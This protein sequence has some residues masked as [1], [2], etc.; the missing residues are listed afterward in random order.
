MI[1]R[2]PLFNR[3]EVGGLQD[4]LLLNHGQYIVQT[5]PGPQILYLIGRT[6]WV[7]VIK[8]H[9][10]PA[11]TNE[12]IEVY[13]SLTHGIIDEE[14]KDKCKILYDQDELIY[15]V[16][17]VK[18]QQFH[19]TNCHDCGYFAL[20]VIAEWW[21]EYRTNTKA[22]C[23][24]FDQLKM[25]EH[26]VFCINNDVLNV[27]PR[28]SEEAARAR[29]REAKRKANN[30]LCD[31]SRREI[32][33]KVE[34][35]KV[36]K[37]TDTVALERQGVCDVDVDEEEEEELPLTFNN[38]TIDV[39]AAC[40]IN[41]VPIKEVCKGL[42][43]EYM[44]KNMVK[45]GHCNASMWPEER[46]NKNY[47]CC[48]GGVVKLPPLPSPP[49]ELMELFQN[50]NNIGRFFRKHVRSFNNRFSFVSLKCNQTTFT[51]KG[52]KVFNIQG[53]LYHR[54]GSLC[55]QD[56]KTPSFAQL[57]L[58]SDEKE[59]LGLRHGTNASL[60][61]RQ[62]DG[63]LQK[64]IHQHNPLRKVYLTA[65][66]RLKEQKE[67]PKFVVR[68]PADRGPPTGA[69]DRTYN[70]PVGDQIAAL[71]SDESLAEPRDIMLKTVKG[72]LVHIHETHNLCDPLSYPL[73]FP[74]GSPG[75]HINLLLSC[76]NE[77]GKIRKRQRL[78]PSMYYTYRFM[79]RESEMC[80]SLLHRGCILFQQFAVDA[81]TKV[82]IY[83]L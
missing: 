58:C 20:A 26:V 82:K 66:Q 60:I 65:A 29:A 62:I 39:D 75:W 74:Y 52:P 37:I 18:Q 48:M 30:L 4:T 25:R 72:P 16:M 1:K 70:A 42:P 49:K 79:I 56:N 34:A 17:V 27:F 53:Q 64:I 32:V 83:V 50:E 2:H 43:G 68:L 63:V 78:T 7:V 36:V 57:Y 5:K 61:E 15:K 59:E 40:P 13:D 23:A 80:Q 46:V 6:H 38:I 54:Y 71:L 73:L 55:P 11:E 19:L 35:K 41:G 77:K 9:D 3:D 31:N 51:G 67:C 69:H 47:F 33:R 8:T 45:C 28:I 12:I 76:E 10:G 22:N 14:I 44:L 81:Y 24:A 21:E